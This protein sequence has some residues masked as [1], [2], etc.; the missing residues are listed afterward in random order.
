ML[1]FFDKEEY[2]R[3][4]LV[5]ASSGILSAP[6][7]VG[8][9]SAI[10]GPGAAL[11]DTVKGRLGMFIYSRHRR[12]VSQLILDKQGANFSSRD[13]A[14]GSDELSFALLAY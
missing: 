13:G 12:F 2:D 10:P 7:C 3:R 4:I 6:H 5:V 8:L 1:D 11:V 9:S 14:P